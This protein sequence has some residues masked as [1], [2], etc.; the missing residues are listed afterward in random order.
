M[1]VQI[2]SLTHCSHPSMRGISHH[3]SRRNPRKFVQK[4][5]E[6]P[7]KRRD[8]PFFNI[9]NVFVS[10]LIHDN[11]PFIA[12]IIIAILLSYLCF[13]FLYP[14][15]L[16]GAPLSYGSS[17]HA[18]CSNAENHIDKLSGWC[19]APVPVKLTF[20]HPR[21]SI[22]NTHRFLSFFR[23]DKFMIL[24]ISCGNGGKIFIQKFGKIVIRLRVDFIPCVI[25]RGF[26]MNFI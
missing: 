19:F 12:L 11:T 20:P 22:Y 16:R 9:S 1:L 14:S 17:C 24:M 15:P 25:H 7:R 8:T 18:D 5:D 26:R 21:F 23:E 2:A 6:K 10:L 3:S 4:Y 13:L